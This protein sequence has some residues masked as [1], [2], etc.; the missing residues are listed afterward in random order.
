[1][2]V[3]SDISSVCKPV[4]QFAFFTEKIEKQRI[5]FGGHIALTYC[6]NLRCVHCYASGCATKEVSCECFKKII[7]QL[8]DEGCL[9]VVFTGGEPL[10]RNDFVSIYEYAANKGILITVFTN[11]TLVNTEHISVLK[12]YPPQEVEVTLLG[13][14]ADIHDSLT[15]CKGSFERA[16]KGVDKLLQH[17]VRVSLKT[18]VMKRNVCQIKDMEFLAR[19]LGTRFRIDGLIF[20]SLNGDKSP[21]TFRVDPSELV[22]IEMDDK[23]RLKEWKNFYQHYG[24]VDIEEPLFRCS[25]GKTCFYIDPAGYLQPC[26][27]TPTIRVDTGGGFRK[28]WDKIGEIVESFD[29]PVSSPCRGCRLKGICG[30]CPGIFSL[31]GTTAEFPPKFLCELGENRYNYLKSNSGV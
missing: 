4:D 21:L 29:L 7:A 15:Q 18:I 28:A 22:K 5:P 20:G 10:I 17:D 16:L 6:C 27:M 25:A 2:T 24:S 3:Q 12:D 31:E 26:V 14:T 9:F 8:A 30:Y 13:A 19:K 1:M 11:A 23:E